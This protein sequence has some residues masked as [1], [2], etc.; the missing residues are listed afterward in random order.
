MKKLLLFIIFF[1]VSNQIL[2]S[3]DIVKEDGVVSF[4]LP[5]RNSLKFNRFLINPT[6]SF[7]REQGSTISFYNKRQ[8]VQFDN[9]PQTYMF[10]YSG[11]F[12]E[13]Q[14]VSVGVFQQNYGVLTTFGGVLNFAQN[15]ELDQD[16]NLTFGLNLAFY[17][18]GLNTAKVITNY[19]DPSLDNIPSNFLLSINPGINYGTAFLDF[20][21]SINNV[22]LYNIKTSKM[23]QDDPEKSIE[24]HAMHTGYL[25]TNGFFDRSKFSAL[26]RTELKK[27]KTVISG[28]VMFA[29]PSGVWAQGGY[30][31]L[32]GMSGGLGLNLT[33]KIS[34]EYNYEKATGS[35][36]N[37][38]S[39]HEISLAY[40]FKSNKYYQDDDEIEGAI[41]NT[42]QAP[43][44]IASKPKP[45]VAPKNN[46]VADAKAKLEAEN[47]AKAAVLAQARADAAAKLKANEDAKAKLAAEAQAKLAAVAQAKADADAK[48]KADAAA[49]AA[50]LAQPKQTEND[51]IKE[52]QAKAA[53]LAQAK[54]D[55][56]AKV[57]AD[58]DA[59]AKALAQAKAATLA[60]EKLDAAT[61]IKA[62]SDAKLSAEA[63][64]KAAALA[65]EKQES[66]AQAKA[67]AA[68]AKEKLDA[69]AK[70][71]ADAD[72]KLAAEAQAKAAALA[73]EK[74]ESDAK[75]S[76]EAQAKAAAL[77]KEKQEADAQAKAA[78]ALA[79]EK[80]DAAAKIK[81]ESDA[82]LTAE[83]QLKAAA[84]AK[85]KQETDAKLS[86]EAQAKAA[87]LAKE[88]QDADA[89]AKAAA[90]L[91]KEKLDAAAKI[92][93]EADA[94]LAAEAQLKA[95]ALAKE[96]QEA[97]AQAKAAAALA[98][99]KLAAEAKI[100][101]EADAKLAAEAQA[102]AA[103]LAKEKQ[104]AAAKIKAETDAKLATEA[105]AKAAA[106]AQQKLEAEA[107][108]KAIADAK[109][110]ADAQAKAAA[111]AKE[112]LEAEAKAKAIVDAKLAAE[113]QA[114]ATAL[115]KE[116]VEA[117][118]KAKLAAE[119]NAKLAAEAQAKADIEN[120]AR[121]ALEAQAKAAALVQEKLDA[122]ARLAADAKAKAI[123]L[124]Q[125]K[126]IL[127]GKDDNARAMKDLSQFITESESGQKDLLS[128][129]DATVAERD[130]ELND[131]KEENDLS[132]KGIFKEPKPFKS[133]SAQNNALAALQASI[134][135]LNKSQNNKIVSLE[136]LYN[137]RLKK[138]NKNDPTTLYYLKTIEALKADQAKVLQTN[139]NLLASLEKIKVETEIE[140]K[141]RIKRASFENDQGRYANDMATLKR[142]KETT[143]LSK[144]VFKP[145]DFNYGEE[146]SNMQ[147]IKSIK[148]VEGGYYLVLAV[149]SDVAKRD[150]FLRKVVAA[151]E[152]NINF[153]YDVNTSKYF[154]YFTKFDSIE[155]AKQV[156]D[157]K[158]NKPYNGKMVMVRVEN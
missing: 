32:Y 147:I 64:A 104:E 156:Q 102:K 58:A 110:V 17:K 143:P 41:I 127:E 124:A 35:L 99:E 140:K 45:A 158:G 6:F 65:K 38:G 115:A 39:S 91:A 18:S 75:L 121:L 48:I 120:K 86:A 76:A 33:P 69:A 117:E 106:L 112:K 66:D 22:F 90:I 100:K 129:L 81:A 97:D 88:K 153:F 87:A 16:S 116:K 67:A 79:K 47:R 119:A 89:Q 31:T 145:Q 9:A 118:A 24:L 12:R 152:K 122:E 36:S 4:T 40:K 157:S 73:K 109:L 154:I 74:Q 131:L 10:G 114:R 13:N 77:A 20:G 3:Q 55:A 42:T 108:A 71:K 57:K 49:R 50:A 56:E 54:L 146:Q 125:E 98:K 134:A 85:E 150:E 113:A 23:V 11:R 78:A 141:R 30:N 61:R 34:I 53:A 68:L 123:A 83:A 105:Q 101:A 19:P 51:R 72:A 155:E 1:Y 103:A 130:K 28:L 144:E 63:Q 26:V 80:L 94:K 15:V 136:N 96:K 46:A 59:R 37:F 29:I 7:V 44:N 142:I 5:I 132:D 149:H 151:G 126:N 133:I 27:E 62:E 139:S 43:K 52:A 111:Q 21:A 95:A 82:K 84:L 8:W 2:Y 70:V 128:K 137:E 93:A 25:E 148:N 107:K 60:K 135:E 138:G 14:G 92:K